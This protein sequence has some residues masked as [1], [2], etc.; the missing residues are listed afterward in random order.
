MQD[1]II[2]IKKLKS[3]ISKKYDLEVENS[4]FFANGILVHNC[5]ILRPLL[6]KYKGTQ[7][8]IS[9]K[10]DGSSITFFIKDGEFG[11][12]SRN[13]ELKETEDNTIWKWARK[14][15]IENKLRG[16]NKNI[17]L[18]GELIGPGVNGN[19][20]NLTFIDIYF[21]DAFDIDKFNYY[22]LNEFKILLENKLKLKTVPIISYDY[23]LED[24]IDELI[25][26]ATGASII[27]PKGIREGIVLR[28]TNEIYDSTV[29]EDNN[30]RIT[31]KVL[32]PEYCL[33]Y[34]T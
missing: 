3:Y 7:F 14:N 8:S 16:L 32:N 6:E 13:L 30:G 22:D 31:F 18:Q 29:M 2:S 20:L 10:L 27:N 19:T 26:K 25:K 24:N 5:Q 12:C 33:K 34:D 4:N 23:W 17:A 11:V 28:P 1:E 21:Y 9:E 15:D